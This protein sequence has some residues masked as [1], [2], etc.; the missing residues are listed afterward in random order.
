MLYSTKMQIVVNGEKG[1]EIVL[2]RGLRQG[3]SLSPLFFVLVADGLNTML[4]KMEN[5]GLIQ[6]LT[7]SATT[8]YVNFQYVDDTHI[9][10]G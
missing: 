4:R 3:D 1:K 8:S 2:K 6:G 7:G 9:R 5:A 10:R